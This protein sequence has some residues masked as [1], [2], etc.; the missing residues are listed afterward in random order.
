VSRILFTAA[1]KVALRCAGDVSGLRV[2][3]RAVR[4]DRM[5]DED[6]ALLEKAEALVAAHDA[7]VE[8]INQRDRPDWTARADTG[9]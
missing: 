1:T 4:S 5:A 6:Q 2:A 8:A 7:L 9:G 3:A